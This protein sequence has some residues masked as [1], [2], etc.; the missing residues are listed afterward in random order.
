MSG[1]D[2]QEVAIIPF[3]PGSRTMGY[4]YGQETWNPLLVLEFDD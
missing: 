3:Q 1:M 2:Y 4:V